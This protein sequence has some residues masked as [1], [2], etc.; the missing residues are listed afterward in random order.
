MT[1]CTNEQRSPLKTKITITKNLNTLLHFLYLNCIHLYQVFC[2][3]HCT[4]DSR[5]YIRAVYT[6][7][8]LWETIPVTPKPHY[9]KQWN[10]PY[11]LWW[12]VLVEVFHGAMSA[13]IF[14]TDDPFGNQHCDLPL[15]KPNWQQQLFPAAI[16]RWITKKCYVIS[17]GTVLADKSNSFSG[18]REHVAL[19]QF[20]S[21]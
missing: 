17:Q 16:A 20:D 8:V 2:T 11:T 10:V 12:T 7:C 14:R 3:K 21:A 13:H 6:V 15:T 1:C 9:R 5:I 18:T 19:W 4:K